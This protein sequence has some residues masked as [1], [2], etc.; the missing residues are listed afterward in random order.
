MR[1][2]ATLWRVRPA[3][4]RGQW[5]SLRRTWRMRR[6]S[7]ER[8]GRDEILLRTSRFPDS[9]ASVVVTQ[10]CPGFMTWELEQLG[11]ARALQRCQSCLDRGAAGPF[12]RSPRHD[13]PTS[14]RA[15]CSIARAFCCRWV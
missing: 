1:G 7:R 14:G 12:D 10:T 3:R 4:G 8:V 9:S 13:A 15:S 5:F 2:G 11:R 6:R